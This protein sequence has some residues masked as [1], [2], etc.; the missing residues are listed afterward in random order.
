M[1]LEEER[2]AG[3]IASAPPPPDQAVETVGLPSHA[4]PRDLAKELRDFAK[5]CDGDLAK[6]IRLS[7]LLA[8]R[9]WSGSTLGDGTGTRGS[10]TTS[11]VERAA[12]IQQD[13]ATFAD[14]R[15][16]RFAHADRDLAAYLAL[17]EQA[18]AKVTKLA[19]DLLA[20][21]DD[22]DELPAGTGNCAC[23]Q[24]FCRPGVT[25]SDNDRLRAGLC[26]ACWKDWSRLGRP[27][28]GVWI[29]ERRN[30]LQAAMKAG[31]GPAD[32]LRWV[33]VD[34]PTGT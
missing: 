16:D 28:R 12:G 24:R 3:E 21:A 17:I 29:L 25:G 22:V 19:T 7:S 20:H 10:D 9:G 26:P 32:L 30:R 5:L 1:N 18:V 31:T 33:S 2:A 8:A 11:S 6:A 34:D 14:I 27:D 4:R 13:V 23:C 15:P